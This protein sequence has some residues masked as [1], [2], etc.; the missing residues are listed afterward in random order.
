METIGVY[1]RAG[2]YRPIERPAPPPDPRV[3]VQLDDEI[4]W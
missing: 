4:Q 1:N 3:Q 2:D